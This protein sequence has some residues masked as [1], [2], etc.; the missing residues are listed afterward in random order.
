MKL[1][2]RH[3]IL[4]LFLIFLS[5]CG[6]SNG[7]ATGIA[8]SEIYVI[9]RAAGGSEIV[10]RASDRVAGAIDSLTWKGKEFIDSSNH[11]RELQSASSFDRFGEAF[12][13]TEAGSSADGTG[14]T[15]TSVL[16]EVSAADNVLQ[17]KTQMAYWLPVDGVKL[18]KHVLT[19][20]VTIGHPA[21]TYVIQYDVKFNVPESHGYGLFEAL[22]AYMPPEFSGFWTFNPATGEL[23]A[24]GPGAHGF[25][26]VFSSGTGYAMGV[27]SPDHLNAQP[28]GIDYGVFDT[29][30][31]KSPVVKWNCVFR[32]TDTPAGDYNFRTYVVVGSLEAVRISMVQLHNYFNP[33]P[34]TEIK[35]FVR[36]PESDN[37]L[38]AYFSINK[39][40]GK[41][42]FGT[43]GYQ[44]GDHSSEIYEYPHTKTASFNAESV[45]HIEKHNGKYYLTLEHGKYN[46]VDKAMIMRLEGSTWKEVYRSDHAV[47]AIGLVS[48]VDGYLY[49]TIPGS[50]SPNSDIVRSKS[51]NPGTWKKWYTNTS[52]YRFFGIASLGTKLL[53]AASSGPGDWGGNTQ[54][55]I[56]INKNLH[57]RDDT[58]TGDGFW[59]AVS[60]NGDGYVGGTGHARVVRVSD[61]KTV[62]DKPDFLT[63][64]GFVVDKSR[65][66][67]FALFNRE[68]PTIIP[69]AEVWATKDGT[70]WYPVGSPLPTAM[71][72]AGYYD[73]E[74]KEVWLVGGRWAQDGSGYGHVFKGVRQ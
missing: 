43:Y 1:T 68:D 24:I 46:T 8:Y 32:Y 65:N 64:H 59:G 37:K 58:R 22:T 47:I 23:G 27:Y 69:G 66:T 34:K 70:R 17:T 50:D 74:T 20:K 61:R 44:N 4:I 57:W 33:V 51:G 26:V 38:S 60:F 10:I 14:P 29:E 9:S 12:N 52:E 54:P 28:D 36:V 45:M 30:L 16:L 21:S 25:P 2:S 6:D 31:L 67:L 62:L 13:P 56:F 7:S 73:E 71:L 19:K 72:F 35:K 42:V 15:S 39:I 49:A 5:G 53:T 48:H 41:M 55:S 63:V 40:N 18:S 11:G 3:C